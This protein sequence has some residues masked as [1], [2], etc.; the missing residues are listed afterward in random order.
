MPTNQRGHKDAFW[1]SPNGPDC[2]EVPARCTLRTVTEAC[3]AWLLATNLSQCAS[4]DPLTL[5]WHSEGTFER[6]IQR[7]KGPLKGKSRGFSLI[8]K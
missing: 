8:L 2:R 3:N 4:C 7:V 1:G 5:N 6:Q